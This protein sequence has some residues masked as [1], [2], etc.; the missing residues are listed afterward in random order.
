MD[1]TNDC[2]SCG[3]PIPAD[4]ASCPGCGDPLAGARE[5]AV[6]PMR[7]QALFAFSLLKSAG[8]HPILA[9]HDE[10]GEP[11]TLE[12]E[13]PFSLGGGLMIPVTTTFGV[14]VPRSEAEESARVLEDA[15]LGGI[16]TET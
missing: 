5:V 9:F 8:F 11:H 2:P 14:Y 16:E 12:A 6:E 4:L 1:A 7:Q 10:G 15:R 3:A 13:E